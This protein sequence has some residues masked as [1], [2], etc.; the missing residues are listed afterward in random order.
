VYPELMVFTHYWLASLFVVADGWKQLKISDPEID[1]MITTHWKSL[2]DFCKAIF[3]FQRQD[4]KHR[5][6]FEADKFNWA[7]KLHSSLRT[8]L[9]LRACAICKSK[10]MDG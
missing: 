3:H 5:Q 4:T 1:A 2:F 8:F 7:E 9:R 10:C 6:M